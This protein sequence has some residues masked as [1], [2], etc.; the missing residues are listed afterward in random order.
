MGGRAKWEGLLSLDISNKVH[1]LRGLNRD[2]FIFNNI[3]RKLQARRTDLEH[4]SIEDRELWLLGQVRFSEQFSEV[5]R[6]VKRHVSVHP[7]RDRLS[8]H[9][10]GTDD[11]AWDAPP[12]ASDVWEEFS[13]DA[14]SGNQNEVGGISELVG[15]AHLSRHA[16]EATSLSIGATSLDEGS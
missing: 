15:R 1:P 5:E 11:V 6:F 14:Q 7:L 10:C 12:P 8:S 13:R 3:H 2:Q 16:D 4:L 9:I